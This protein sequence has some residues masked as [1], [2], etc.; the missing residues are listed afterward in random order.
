MELGKSFIF[1]KYLGRL[2]SD[3]YNELINTVDNKAKEKW[4][5]H[6]RDYQVKVLELIE[7]KEREA[8]SHL[9]VLPTGAGKTEIFISYLK[10]KLNDFENVFILVPKI[11][12]I[13]EVKLRLK[14]YGIKEEDIG[15]LSTK[16]EEIKK[17]NLVLITSLTEKRKHRFFENINN[18]LLILD[19]FHNFGTKRNLK[20]LEEILNSNFKRKLLFTATP[21]RHDKIDL[22]DYTQDVVATLDLETL[23]KHNYLCPY[24][25]VDENI[26]IENAE[27]KSD[28][29]FIFDEENKYNED[30]DIDE[31]AEFLDIMAKTIAKHIKERKLTLIFTTK[32]KIA[33][34]LFER[35]Q[36]IISEK[37]GTIFHGELPKKEREKM[38]L[39]LKEGKYDYI[40]AVDLLSEGIDVPFIDQII[41]I[42]PLKSLIKFI[43]TIGRGLRKAEGKKDLKL[44]CINFIFNEKAYVSGE[45]RYVA[46]SYKAMLNYYL[47]QILKTTRESKKKTKAKVEKILKSFSVSKVDRYRYNLLVSNLNPFSEEY[48]ILLRYGF[49]NFYFLEKVDENYFNVYD[50]SLDDF[51]LLFSFPDKD[52]ALEEMLKLFYENASFYFLSYIE[53]TFLRKNVKKASIE[54]LN[55]IH[56]L[57]SKKDIKNRFKILLKNNLNVLMASNLISF[58]RL[59]EILSLK[60][61]LNRDIVFSSYDE[62]ILYLDKTGKIL[63]ENQARNLQEIE[64]ILNFTSEKD[65]NF[66][67]SPKLLSYYKEKLG[68][69]DFEALTFSLF[70]KTKNPYYY[71]KKENKEKIIK[72]LNNLEKNYVFIKKFYSEYDDYEVFKL[73]INEKNFINIKDYLKNI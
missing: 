57:I 66:F 51:K 17:I 67:V 24:K 9:C 26:Y 29:E 59:Y 44:V 16:K 20:L 4:G 43:Q 19:E 45:L 34:I 33:N 70:V 12:L 61:K 21:F 53:K 64:F 38:F 11:E 39:S 22:F 71:I 72:N 58:F 46:M 65:E 69:K 55:Y 10:K 40:F 62:E 56:K 28:I 25:V 63:Y 6:L 1:E 73:A 15:E 47:S 2:N 37:K 32:R 8:R 42:R 54:Q 50:V 49:N 18:S 48:Q 30:F 5:A 36:K 52:K 31:E 3:N 27:R 41:L 23:I 14:K 35:V 60:K 7:E 68:Y 13:E